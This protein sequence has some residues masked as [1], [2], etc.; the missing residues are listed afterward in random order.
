MQKRIYTLFLATLIGMTLGCFPEQIIPD[1]IDDGNAPPVNIYLADSP[2][3]MS[4]RNPYGQASSPYAGPPERIDSR[5]YISGYPGLCTV[6]VS[7]VYQDG[8]R[9]LWGNN[10]TTVFKITTLGETI[11]YIDLL[12]KENELG[13]PDYGGE[14]PGLTEKA[15]S[16]AYILLDREGTFFVPNFKRIFAF[17]DS[18]QGDPNSEIHVRG[19]FEIPSEELNGPQDKIVG[20]NITHDGMLAIA[21]SMGIVAVI[22]RDFTQAFYLNLGDGQEE[23]SN[24]IACDEEGGIYV[25]TSKKMYRVQWSGSELSFDES[26]GG[27]YADYETGDDQAG[28][29]LGLGSGS[30]PTLMGTGNQD[31]FVVITDA[32]DLM[33]LVLFWRN[34]IPDNWI[35]IPDSKDRRIA[36]QMPVTFGD[37]LA[38]SSLSEQS[39]CVRGYGA[40]VV[41]NQLALNDIGLDLIFSGVSF[42][43]PYGAEKFE[44]DPDEKK[45]R[46]AWA[47][48][49]ISLPNGIPTMSSTTNLIYDI[50]QRNSFWT[51]EALDWS[52]G[53]SVFHYTLGPN[54]KY[55]SA[56]AATQIG[57]NGHLYSGT[58][59][60]MLR[61]NP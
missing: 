41:N 20:L 18:T 12:D 61:L 33:H 47:N 57:L 28:I 42:I 14:E 29:R 46:S 3:P 11:S 51:M 23:I 27:W 5:S 60:G 8:S 25:V 39:V 19:V 40:L 54:I 10:V 26:K 15:I 2:W 50:G 31:K 48:Q 34:D 6:A 38:T 59:L 58:A 36:G 7:N 43:A 53:E 13:E 21:T 55:N 1:P 17:R 24:S 49:E 44:W 37:P 56:Y 52:T 32:Q 9:V 4:H 35:Q 45:L 16:G 30:T 22:S